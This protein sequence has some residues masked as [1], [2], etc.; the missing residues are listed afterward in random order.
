MVFAV[1]HWYISIEKICISQTCR[2]DIFD[3]HCV[4]KNI[5]INTSYVVILDKFHTEALSFISDVC[6]MFV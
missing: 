3:T 4:I 6:T 1:E 2:N 5:Q